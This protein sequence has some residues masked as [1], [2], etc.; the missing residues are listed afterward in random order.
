MAETDLFFTLSA[1]IIAGVLAGRLAE[2]HKF[3]RTIP[4]IVTGILLVALNT[5]IQGPVSIQ[6]LQAINEITLFIAELAL[7]TILFE[8]GMRLNLKALKGYFGTVFLIATVG[9][10]VN[11][12]I[13]GFIAIAVFSVLSIL[14][15]LPDRMSLALALLLGAIFTP[16]DPAATFAILRGGGTRVKEKMETMLGGESAFN[17]VFAIIL[18][19]V[20]F[21]PLVESEALGTSTTVT[22]ADI[23]ITI[24]W[25]FLGGALLGFGIGLFFLRFIQRLSDHLEES[26]ISLTA[27]AL[28]F[29]VGYLIKISAPIGALVAGIVFANPTLFRQQDY[30]KRS[31]FRFWDGVTWIFELVAFIFIGALFTIIEIRIEIIIFAVILS[32]IVIIGRFIGTFVI[33]LPLELKE[34]TKDHFNT[35]ERFFVGFAGMKGLTTAILALM[36]L[37]EIISLETGVLVIETLLLNSTIMVLIMTG[38][39]QGIFLKPFAG[40]MGVL[41]EQ[42]ELEDIQAERII[43]SAKLEYIVNEFDKGSITAEQFRMLSIPL[44]EN[45]IEARERILVL[46]AEREQA[47]LMFQ[48]MKK[49]YEHARQAL[50]NAKQNQR[51]GDQSFNKALDKLNKEKESLDLRYEEFSGRELEN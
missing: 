47:H 32:L 2:Q 38:L 16:T 23:L 33:T 30:F 11:T 10:V 39:L 35:K 44:K 15:A 34:K 3:P 6:E 13:I 27:I 14:L 19:S 4:L 24:A 20:I 12:F 31:M 51:I 42:D 41:E 25:Q 49:Q 40:K 9:T 17:D 22:F 1:V 46:R 36:A 28:I 7:V 48:L 21:I 26:F 43:T 8:E 5:L 29:A 18:V 37:T 45:L 50:D